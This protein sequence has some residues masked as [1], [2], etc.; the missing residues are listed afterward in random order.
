MG[1]EGERTQLCPSCRM[2]VP[3]VA[4]QCRFCGEQLRTTRAEEG[5][6]T[7]DQ[8]NPDAGSEFIEEGYQPEVGTQG[9]R[10]EEATYVLGT[11][12]SRRPDPVRLCPSCRN[13]I[14]VLATVCHYCG[15]Q[16]GRPRTQQRE[17][18]V[19]DL[20]GETISHVGVSHSVLQAMETFR[21]AEGD[22]ETEPKATVKERAEQQLRDDLAALAERVEMSPSFRPAQ[23]RRRIGDLLPSWGWGL[24]V[25]AF[26]LGGAIVAFSYWP[27][28]EPP[29]PTPIN[30][31]IGM[32]EDGADS[33]DTLAAAS[34]FRSKYGTGG[35]D[36]VLEEARRRV[37]A[38]IRSLLSLEPYDAA[39]HRT[40][41]A[42]ADKAHRIDPEGPFS[43][44]RKEIALEMRAY[45]M[46]LKET[47]PKADPPTASI[48]VMHEDRSVGVLDLAEGDTFYDGRFSLDGVWSDSVL[49]ID[50][51]RAGRRLRIS[52][53]VGVMPFE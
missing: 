9:Q 7:P 16:V 45:N 18:T 15:E 24:I 5:G 43:A 23:T 12:A 48:R 26:I 37:A 44:L 38:E 36:E 41:D 47:Q 49:V 46:L 25:L 28:E 33:F 21:H 4:R 53:I 1:T 34:R 20:G 2:E 35:D 13:L 39:T 6:K 32:L 10:E 17:L 31:A 52:K 50:H 14:S 30:P 42:M 40:A 27:E 8:E 22:P 19:E 3:R 11:K 29:P 51:K